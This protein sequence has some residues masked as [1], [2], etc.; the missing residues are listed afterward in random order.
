MVTATITYD[1]SANDIISMET[2]TGRTDYR[3]VTSQDTPVLVLELAE[4]SKVTSFNLS[5]RLVSSVPECPILTTAISKV[6]EASS[7]ETIR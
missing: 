5:S 4:D 2:E 7:M 3:F 6:V 1:C